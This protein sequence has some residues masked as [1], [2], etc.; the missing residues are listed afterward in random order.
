MPIVVSNSSPL[1]HLAKIGKF[2]LLQEFFAEICV[3]EAVYKECI[4]EGRDR[5]EV[6]L[7]RNAEWIHVINGIEDLP[8]LFRVVVNFNVLSGLVGSFTI[9]FQHK[10]HYK[11][12]THCCPT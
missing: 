11:T 9:F 4:A 3:P 12:L 6:H 2:N 1:I 10:F 8:C 5:E 7:I